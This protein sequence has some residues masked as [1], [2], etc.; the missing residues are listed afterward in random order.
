MARF[1]EKNIFFIVGS[2]DESDQPRFY[3]NFVFAMHNK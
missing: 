2:T 3:L 1:T